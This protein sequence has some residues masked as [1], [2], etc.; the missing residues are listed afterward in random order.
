MLAHRSSYSASRSTIV[1]S[2]STNQLDQTWTSK[3]WANTSELSV[4]IVEKRP[5]QTVSLCLFI[6]SLVCFSIVA[7]ALG[8]GLG[9]GYRQYQTTNRSAPSN[10]SD[11]Y[12][13]PED[14]DF[15][16]SDRLINKTELELDTDFVITREPRVREY[17]F[18][19]TQA[20]A[21]P[22]GFPKPMVLVNEQSPGP[23]IEANTGDIIRVHVYNLMVNQ[24]TTIHWHGIN[25]RRTPWMDG[26]AG[27]SQ[28]A[29]P[30]L[31]NFTYEF[32]VLDQRGTFWWHAHA[33]VQYSDGAYGAIIIHD[34]DEMVPKT[35]DEKIVFVSDVYHTYGSTVRLAIIIPD[36]HVLSRTL[37]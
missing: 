20:N 5:R 32:R 18:N 12:G 16:L 34:P 19:T 9:L 26:V 36:L 37:S 24:S 3:I 31:Q 7:L 2:E 22:D 1:D 25:Q 13:V 23:L 30:P 33:S 35:D 14:L 27:V 11:N 8:L 17:V 6:W 4:A 29:I 28:C 15:V 10:Y 21:A